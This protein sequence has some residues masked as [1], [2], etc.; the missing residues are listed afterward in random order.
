[1]SDLENLL[2][3]TAVQAESMKGLVRL[4][5]NQLGE[6]MNSADCLRRDRDSSTWPTS[7]L[8]LLSPRKSE[9]DLNDGQAS[10]QSILEIILEP[11]ANVRGATRV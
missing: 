2:R 5:Q 11:Q 10:D 9:E 3:M 1:M 7:T 4:C 8:V 6:A